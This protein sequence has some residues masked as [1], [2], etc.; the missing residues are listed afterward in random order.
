MIRYLIKIQNL[1]VQ[2]P[3]VINKMCNED[4]TIK[5]LQLCP[6]I[7]GQSKPSETLLLKHFSIFFSLE[8]N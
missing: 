1:F 3:F 4:H 7:D 8:Y 5:V 6:C 2:F